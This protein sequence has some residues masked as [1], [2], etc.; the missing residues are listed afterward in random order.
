M[1]E[2]K[3]SSTF[4]D[5]EKLKRAIKSGRVYQQESFL[6]ESQVQT[7]LQEISELEKENAFLRK[8]LSNTAVVNKFDDK[9][10]RSI[11][12]VPWFTDALK[13][14]D[15]REI[16]QIIRRLQKTLSAVLDKPTL[17]DTSI[18]HECYYSKSEVGSRLPRHLDER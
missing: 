7:V 14:E 13:G 10:D 2:G 1:L 8:G 6:S 16:P 18:P 4:L 5:G 15:T 12:P 9:L 3:E 17:G 11:C